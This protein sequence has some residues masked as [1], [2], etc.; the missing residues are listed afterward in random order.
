MFIQQGLA[1]FIRLLL[2]MFLV[3]YAWLCSNLTSTAHVYSCV[4][5]AYVYLCIR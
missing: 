1:I 3:S 2:D 4:V 5:I